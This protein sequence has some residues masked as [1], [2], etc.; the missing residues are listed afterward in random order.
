MFNLNEYL[1]N[2]RNR[3]DYG[4][5]PR[6]VCADGFSLSVQANKGA[7]SSPRNEIGPWTEAEIG[8]PS[9]RVEEIMPYCE[10]AENPTD[11][12]YA[13]VPVPLIEKLIE[14]HGGMK[15]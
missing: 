9:A 3:P 6:I 15:E 14:S 8:F 4:Q 10:D 13:Y 5:V 11:T 2:N 12:V 1:K 7:Y